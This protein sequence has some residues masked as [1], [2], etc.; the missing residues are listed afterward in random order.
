MTAGASPH[1]KQTTGARARSKPD[2][3]N[4]REYL[5]NLTLARKEG[6]RAMVEAPPLDRPDLLSNKALRRL[7]AS[8]AGDYNDQRRRWHAQMGTVMT[9]ECQSVL[10]Q[11]EDFVA[12]NCQTGEDAKPLIALSGLPGLGKSTV[13]RVFGKRV[14]RRHIERYG[15]TTRAGDERWPVCRIGMTAST[16]TREFN[17]ALCDFYAHPGVSRASAQQLLR[18]ALDDVSSCETRLLIIDDLHFLRGRHERMTDLSNQFKYIANEFPLTVLLIGIGLHERNALL[19]DRNA[20]RDHEME[21]LLRCTTPVDMSPFRV[22]TETQRR[23]WREL[24]LTLE[25]RLLLTQKYPG[26]LAD[27]LSDQLF[28]RST[29]HIG[30]LMALIR[31]ACQ[32]AMRTGTE[33]LTADLIDTCRIDS[34]AE[35]GRRELQAAFRTGRKTTRLRAATSPP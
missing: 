1:S 17:A 27:D 25:Q 18:C 14:H 22:D 33:K 28:V 12:C 34:A 4:P 2:P 30:S 8:A 23:R 29:G 32:K 19:D 11:L 10:E 35:L 24:L 20:Y 3:R 15:V 21:Q 6:W 16:G 13:S 26:M 9:A 31:L 7:S 5:D